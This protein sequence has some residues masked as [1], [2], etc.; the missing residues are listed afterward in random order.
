MNGNPVVQERSTASVVNGEYIIHSV[1]FMR[2]LA[3]NDY[4]ECSCTFSGG[5]LNRI[6]DGRMQVNI[7]Y[8]HGK[9]KIKY[10]HNLVWIQ[11]NGKFDKNIY[12]VHHIDG[13]YENNKIKNTRLAIN[14]Q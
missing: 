10:I 13:D 11:V 7:K 4:L 9:Y 5:S 14:S 12:Y 8:N 6:N 2:T 3:V 1:S